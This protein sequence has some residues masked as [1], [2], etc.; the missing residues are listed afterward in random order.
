MPLPG[1][2]RLPPV[3]LSRR[4][5]TRT[6]LHRPSTLRTIPRII[7]Y[8]SRYKDVDAVSK[9]NNSYLAQLRTNSLVSFLQRE[10]ELELI[11]SHHNHRVGAATGAP[12]PL[13]HS[14]SPPALTQV[15]TPPPIFLSETRN[16]LEMMQNRTRR[17]TSNVLRR[18]RF[19]RWRGT[20]PPVTYPGYLLHFLYVTSLRVVYIA[21]TISLE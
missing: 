3:I 2:I 14:Y 17:V 10:V 5:I 15:T 4:C 13:P 8:P 20:L 18:P 6:H 11:E 12:L 21:V 16:Q 19:S 7:S 9:R 1:D